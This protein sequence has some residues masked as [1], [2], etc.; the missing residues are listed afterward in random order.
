MPTIHLKN[1]PKDIRKIVLEKQV[2]IKLQKEVRLFSQQ[3]TIYHII[4]EW[5]KMSTAK[6]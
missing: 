1:L 5:K 3:L 6:K 2:E 4:R